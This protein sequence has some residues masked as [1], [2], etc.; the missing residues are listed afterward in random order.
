MNTTPVVFEMETQEPDDFLTLLWLLGH[1]R[2]DLRGVVLTPGSP[3]Q[4][5]LV[6]KAL[7]W[8]DAEETPVGAYDTSDVTRYVPNWHEEAFGKI[9]PSRDAEPG[10]ALL[11]RECDESV[12]LLTGAP[13]KNLGRALSHAGFTL[14]R[15]IVQGGF[16]GQGIVETDDQLDKFS[17]L[18]T[19]PSFNLNGSPQTV[20]QALQSDK[21]G[22]RYFVSK[23][24]CHNLV[25]NEQLHRR[26]KPYAD[27]TPHMRRIW[28]GM[29]M[30]LRRKRTTARAPW[31]LPDD[32]DADTVQLIHRGEQIAA[33]LPLAPFEVSVAREMAA[34][35]GLDLLLT[36]AETD[37]PTATLG[38]WKPLEYGKKVKDI[39]AACCVLDLDIATWCE[40]DLFKAIGRWGS[41]PSNDTATFITTA[42]DHHRFFEVFTST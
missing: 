24:V 26:L 4:I 11:V 35:Q 30:Y 8:F 3:W 10:D 37:P 21:I 34:E 23:N 41:E 38:K 20:I 40:V 6:R 18:K 13:P 15:W 29:E 36:D 5:G 14:G 39:L 19:S 7:G 31:P 17:G 25:W 27:E 12:T 42:C 22:A 16:A 2:I 1:P 33:D 28:Q 9:A 32:F